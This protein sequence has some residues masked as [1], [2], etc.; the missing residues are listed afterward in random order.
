MKLPMKS[1]ALAW[2]QVKKGEVLLGSER[3]GMEGVGSEEER[4]QL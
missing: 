3:S 2:E 4:P 1:F